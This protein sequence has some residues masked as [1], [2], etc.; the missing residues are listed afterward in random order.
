[1][2][3]L[4]L[5]ICKLY[6]VV[7]EFVMMA[8]ERYHEACR[9]MAFN[10]YSTNRKLYFLSD[11]DRSFLFGRF[12]TLR[13]SDEFEISWRNYNEPIIHIELMALHSIKTMAA[14]D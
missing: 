10:C 8:E 7:I 3:Q 12:D 14:L 5:Q 13:L 2:I 1:M 9:T 6:N 4:E 11:Q